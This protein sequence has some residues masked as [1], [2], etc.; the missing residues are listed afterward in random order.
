MDFDP[1]QMMQ[2]FEAATRRKQRIDGQGVSV[3]WTYLLDAIRGVAAIGSSAPE[4]PVFKLYDPERGESFSDLYT[5]P[6]G[7]HE[8]EQGDIRPN[9]MVR[10]RGAPGMQIKIE[11]DALQQTGLCRIET[12]TNA[13]FPDMPEISFHDAIENDRAGSDAIARVLSWARVACP[14]ERRAELDEGYLDEFQYQASF[15]RQSDFGYFPF[16]D[17]PQ[18]KGEV[19]RFHDSTS[20]VDK[21]FAALA[22]RAPS[23]N[24]IG[25]VRQLEIV[26]KG[27]DPALLTF[28]PVQHGQAQSGIK[29]T[30]MTGGSTL[31]IRPDAS[32]PDLR[33]QYRFSD[34][35]ELTQF[36]KAG[37]GPQESFYVCGHIAAWIEREC[38]SDRLMDASIMISLANEIGLSVPSAHAD[39]PTHGLK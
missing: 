9:P 13:R 4:G 19:H 37:A 24:V 33:I 14:P 3:A 28:E 15:G 27:F 30:M 36:M 26:S 32:S 25:F 31:E 16:P 5:P 11:W 29:L 1:N 8:S 10:L 22:Q 34:G 18:P 6:Q 23:N 20:F 21:V 17:L 12:Y 39:L 38:P 35:H 2:Q 7:T